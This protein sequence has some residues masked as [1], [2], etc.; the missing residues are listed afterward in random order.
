MFQKATILPFVA[1]RTLNAAEHLDREPSEAY[2]TFTVGTKIQALRG[3]GRSVH[4]SQ[5]REK[6]HAL[7]EF[8]NPQVSYT[9]ANSLIH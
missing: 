9:S 2:T 7:F 3:G 1:V 6:W 8:R 4:L 5:D